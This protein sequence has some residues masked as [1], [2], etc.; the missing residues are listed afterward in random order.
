MI[1]QMISYFTSNVDS[2]VLDQIIKDNPLKRILSTKEAAE[3]VSFL[4]NCS[5]HINGIDLVI[6]SAENIN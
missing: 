6:N 5:E 2:R 3:S 4:V 1:F